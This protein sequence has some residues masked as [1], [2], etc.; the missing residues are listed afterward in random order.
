[1]VKQQTV[2]WMNRSTCYSR[3]Y[4]FVTVLCSDVT[5]H[6]WLLFLS[7]FSFCFLFVFVFLTREDSVNVLCWEKLPLNQFWPCCALM[8]PTWKS[9]YVDRSGVV[10]LV[11]E[12][13]LQVCVKGV[14]GKKRCFCFLFSLFH[15]VYFLYSKWRRLFPLTLSVTIKESLAGGSASRLNSLCLIFCVQFSISLHCS[16]ASHTISLNILP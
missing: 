12:L 9:I 4:L 15:R 3:V 11:L 1:M 8:L 14:G 6:V 7:I 5:H 2:R 10:N 13:F 16:G